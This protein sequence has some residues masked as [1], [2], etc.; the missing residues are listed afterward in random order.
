MD[1]ATASAFVSLITGLVALVS[2]LLKAMSTIASFKADL[3][4]LDDK[5]ERLRSDHDHQLDRQLL[6]VNGCR[7]RIEHIDTRIKG[8]LNRLTSTTEDMEAWLTKNTAYERR[9]S[10][11]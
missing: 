5:I 10:N 8:Q 3:A 9:R 11:N 2:V 4:D 1:I 7:E 6:I